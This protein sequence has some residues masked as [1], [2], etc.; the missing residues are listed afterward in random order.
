MAG[1][2]DAILKLSVA[3][4]LLGAGA[5]VG[6]YYSAYLP[7]RDAKLDNER[8]LETAHAEF[9]RKVAEE[10]A[11]AERSAAEDRQARERAAVQASYDACINRVVAGYNASWASNCKR[12]A[13]QARK[14]RA[15]CT[16]TAESCDLIFPARDAGPDCA[17]PPNLASSL[18][19]QVDRDKDRCL[20]ESRA[21]LQ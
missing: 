3:V 16:G 1:P 17:L 12:L 6:Y 2:V 20:Q 11:D 21:G 8:R 4:S 10:H 7:A 18:D 5:S 19:T 13:D 14:S 9:A 15:G